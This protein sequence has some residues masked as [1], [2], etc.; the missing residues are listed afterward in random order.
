MFLIILLYSGEKPINSVT[1]T[2]IQPHFL[3]KTSLP[4]FNIGGRGN[5][6]TF[7]PRGVIKHRRR[8]L[9]R[10]GGSD[11]FSLTLADAFNEGFS[12]LS[13]LSFCGSARWFDFPRIRLDR[14]KHFPF[15]PHLRAGTNG[16]KRFPL[17]LKWGG[18]SIYIFHLRE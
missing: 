10:D 16:M 6:N 5:P 18:G 12:L 1:G 14:R 17:C 7:Y 9:L 8:R 3:P 15:G 2:A 13:E 4:A 11:G